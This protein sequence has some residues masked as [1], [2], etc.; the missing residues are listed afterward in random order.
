MQSVKE[1]IKPIDAEIIVIDNNSNDGSCEFIKTKYPEVI[2]IENK[3]NV[4][5]AKGNNQGVQIAQGEYV[6]IL[7]PDTVVPSSIF[8][9]LIN[10]LNCLP[11]PGIIA[12]RLIDGTGHF[13]QESKRN[14]PS[15]LTSFRRLFGLKL[16]KVKNYYAD[17]IPDHAISD[18]D[19]LVGAFMLMKREVYLE[20]GGFDEDYFMYGEDIDLSYKIK[21]KGWINYYNGKYTVIHF[22]GESTDR[23]ADYV[24]RF[25]GA[26]RIF[27][28][29][30]FKS[31]WIL[32]GIVSMGIRM[33]SAIQLLKDC[34]RVKNTVDE[35]ILISEDENLRILLESDFRKKVEIFNKKLLKSSISKKKPRTE[36][37]FDNDYISYNSIIENLH[38]LR[39]EELTFKIRPSGCNFILGSDFSDEKGEVIIF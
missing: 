17:H 29:K 21:K 7:N 9:S 23:N 4:G 19:I 28:K 10:N 5:F 15:P 32:D 25:Y 14:I 11:N 31:N 38:A 20:V 16:G 26:M 6:C 2:L 34:N 35:Y 13:L 33:V 36:V 37:I 24:K 18:V 27:Y 39:S 8:I 12:P 1:A 22:K 30:H 3:E